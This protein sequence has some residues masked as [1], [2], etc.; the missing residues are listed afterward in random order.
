M[1]RRRELEKYLKD[2]FQYEKFEDYCQNGLQ[3][4][5]KEEI[6]KLIFGVSFNQPFLEYAIQEHGD[7]IL[8]HHGF[9]GKIS[10]FFP[11]KGF[12]ECGVKV[13]APRLYGFDIEF[14]KYPQD[15]VEGQVQT[16]D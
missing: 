2:L 13:L 16:F 15:L 6:R 14:F 1:V 10:G 12:I 4:E 9:F 5:G 11:H 7:A 3:V 8:V